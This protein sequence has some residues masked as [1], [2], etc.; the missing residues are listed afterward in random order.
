MDI[1]PNPVRTAAEQFSL[2]QI[3]RTK[4]GR[5]VTNA[6]GYH[7][8]SNHQIKDDGFGHA[9]DC[10]FVIDGKAVWEVPDTWWKA[11]GS[12]AQAVG[13]TW[14]GNW[15]SFPDRPHVELPKVF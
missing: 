14:G 4:P 11:Y 12:L 7:I 13:L 9:V 6:D 15:K 10:H 1:T 3:G 2:Y 5:I 8:K